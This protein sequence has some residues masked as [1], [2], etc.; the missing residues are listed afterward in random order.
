MRGINKI[1]V[2]L[3]NG[4]F[5]IV[6]NKSYRMYFHLYCMIYLHDSMR[7]ASLDVLIVQ[8]TNYYSGYDIVS[9]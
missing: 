6:C 9:K 1:D 3:Q 8:V 7:D 2:N 4:L 5:A